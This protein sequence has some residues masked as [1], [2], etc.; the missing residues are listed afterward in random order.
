MIVVPKNK[1]ENVLM[2]QW[3]CNILDEQLEI[4][5]FDRN[6]DPLFQTLGFERGGDLICVIVIHQYVKP[7]V[8]MSVAATSP[9]WAA[10]GNIAIIGKWIFE[11]LGCGRIT[12][13]IRKNNKRARRISE[14]L[15]FQHEGKLRRAM[16]DG[17]II[18][19]GLLK[20]DHKKWLRKAFNGQEDRNRGTSP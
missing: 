4:F 14:G 12:A 5:G 10:K 2:A 20:E 3:A 6:G 11:D 1:A 7:N 16:N 18:L 9:R 15:G 13:I 17:D 19:Y 8:T